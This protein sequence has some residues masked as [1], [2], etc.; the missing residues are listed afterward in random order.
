MQRN[1]YKW[2]ANSQKRR[3]I[4]VT[5]GKFCQENLF[6]ILLQNISGD[7]GLPRRGHTAKGIYGAGAL[8][9]A[10]FGDPCVDTQF[11]IPPN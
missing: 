2:V 10:G 3:L 8:S 1:V 11:L 4:A 9:G 6:E 7:A 5:Y